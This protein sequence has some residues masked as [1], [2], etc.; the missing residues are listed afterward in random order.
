MPENALKEWLKRLES[1]HPIEIDLGLDRVAAVAKTLRLTDGRI[2]TFSIAGTNGKGSVASVLTAGLLAAGYSVGTY[3]SPHLSRFNERILINGEQVDDASIVAAFEAIEL[4][5]RDVSLTYFE[6]ATLAALWIFRQRQVGQQVLEVGLGGRLDA[7]NIIDAHVS[8]I[9]SIGLDH[10]DWLGDSRELIAIEKAGIARRGRPCIVAEL[11]PP[12]TLLSVLAERGA[13]GCFIG[14]DWRIT[15][16]QLNTV[17]GCSVPLPRPPGLLESNVGAAL[18]AIESSGVSQ[19]TDALLAAAG[20]A[21]VAG[22]LTELELNGIRVVL[23][24]AHNTESV[25]R[26]VEFLRQD[27]NQPPTRALFGVMRDKPVRDM[28]A[29]CAGV[30]EDWSVIDLRDV[31]RAMPVEHLAAEIGASRVAMTGPFG[32]VWSHVLGRSQPGDRI[33]VFGSFFT[34]SEALESVAQSRGI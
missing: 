30:F 20:T 29:A 22:R 23:D 7:V 21:S 11:D 24:V 9:T 25:Q 27:P 4:A 16:G 5:R 2:H 31:P 18:Q 34:V 32:E 3:T 13:H 26:L 14:S 33:V 17:Q 12:D 1:R 19:M 6:T 15:N 10:T 8:V 28:L